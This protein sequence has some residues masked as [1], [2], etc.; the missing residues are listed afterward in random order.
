MALA[1]ANGV[2]RS[3]SSL[4]FPLRLGLRQLRFRLIERCN[5][6]T[7]IDLK[8]DI[9]LTD[10]GPFPVVLPDKVSADVRL[11]LCVHIPV[12]YRHPFAVNGHILLDDGYNF[13]GRRSRRWSVRSGSTSR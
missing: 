3:T 7:R 2:S 8:K 9:A 5:E 13:D 6:R 12:Q 10:D 4:A 1:W 11:N